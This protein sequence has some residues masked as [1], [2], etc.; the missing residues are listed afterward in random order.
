MNSKKHNLVL[1]LTPR[2]I[3]GEGVRAFS[4]YLS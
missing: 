3:G 1:T 4:D 2:N